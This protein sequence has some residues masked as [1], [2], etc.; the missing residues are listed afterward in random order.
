MTHSP[1]TPK[2]GI[3][4]LSICPVEL[5]GIWIPFFIVLQHPTASAPWLLKIF[6]ILYFAGLLAIPVAIVGLIKDEPRWPALVA[7]IFGIANIFLC[8][9]PLIL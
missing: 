9:V 6:G 2:Y 3:V 4:A 8:A 5:I 1:P 7:L